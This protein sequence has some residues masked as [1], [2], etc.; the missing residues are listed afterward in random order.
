MKTMAPIQSTR[1]QAQEIIGQSIALQ[2]S[3]R[4]L[5]AASIS[6]SIINYAADILLPLI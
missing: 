3:P 1:R 5:A 2:P 6:T 4:S